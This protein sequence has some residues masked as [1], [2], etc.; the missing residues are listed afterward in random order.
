MKLILILIGLG[1]TLAL[2]YPPLFGSVYKDQLF[3]A[4][5]IF[6]GLF[7]LLGSLGRTVDDW[8]EHKARNNRM[9]RKLSKRHLAQG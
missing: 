6:A 3:K 8:L 4:L 5:L 7:I 2:F 9:K 1:L